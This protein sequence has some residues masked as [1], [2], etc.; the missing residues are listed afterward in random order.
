MGFISISSLD[1]KDVYN[2]DK[3]ADVNDTSTTSDCVPMLSKWYAI[4]YL[5]NFKI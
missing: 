5:Y 1:F 4:F 3:D 2:C